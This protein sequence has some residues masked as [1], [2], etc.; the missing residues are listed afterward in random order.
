MTMSDY[1]IAL[2][3][4]Y[5]VWQQHRPHR[6][7]GKCCDKDHYDKRTRGKLKENAEYLDDQVCFRER[8]WRVY[9]RLRDN[10]PQIQH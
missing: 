3:Q 8:A 5:R 10:P 9:V 6:D 2:Q 4:A 1:E 7:D